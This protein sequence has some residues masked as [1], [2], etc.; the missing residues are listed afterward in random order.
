MLGVCTEDFE[1]VQRVEL[2]RPPASATM[3]TPGEEVEAAAAV[4]MV[5]ALYIDVQGNRVADI[6]VRGVIYSDG[7]GGGPA[8]LLGTTPAV[9]VLANASRSFVRLPFATAVRVNRTD[10]IWIGEQAGGEAPAAADDDGR[11]VG[12]LSCYARACSGPCQPLRYM[13]WPYAGDRPMT[14]CT[15][16]TR[17]QDSAD[18]PC[19]QLLA[20]REQQPLTPAWNHEQRSVE[21]AVRADGPKPEFGP[22]ANVTV[23]AQTLSIFAATCTDC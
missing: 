10:P 1:H 7:G 22:A 14:Y 6:H 21:L 3:T 11:P 4:M 9:L 12:A 18:N 17:G 13:P 2:P 19:P 15:A 5:G 20:T 16:Y 23:S 8:A